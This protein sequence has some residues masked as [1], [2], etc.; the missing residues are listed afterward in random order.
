MDVIQMHDVVPRRVDFHSAVHEAERA[1]PSE[2]FRDGMMP[3]EDRH[4]S[5]C[6]ARRQANDRMEGTMG[7]YDGMRVTALAL[8]AVAASFGM[9]AAQDDTDASSFMDFAPKFIYEVYDM[10]KPIDDKFLPQDRLG[11]PKF[12]QACIDSYNAEIEE[13]D[14]S[15]DEVTCAGVFVQDKDWTLLRNPDKTPAY[16]SMKAQVVIKQE[17]DHYVLYAT[18]IIQRC[19]DWDETLKP[20]AWS[21][22]SWA[23]PT[24]ADWK[25]N[26]E[27][28]KKLNA[29]QVK[30]LKLK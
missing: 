16:R 22:L 27:V 26:P 1:S 13:S 3:D 14:A 6:Q 5:R 24:D 15:E 28:A 10:L 2:R 9:V 7:K 19:T 29:S 11:N 20:T 21:G 4:A 23:E 30:K 12:N 8:V 25:T 18:D 17:P